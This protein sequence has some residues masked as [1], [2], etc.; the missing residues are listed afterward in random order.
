MIDLGTDVEG[1]PP[2]ALGDAG[3]SAS[4][5]N[6]RYQRLLDYAPSSSAAAARQAVAIAQL[7]GSFTAAA[8]AAARTIVEELALP[9]EERTAVPIV[10][11]ESALDA[12]APSA[13]PSGKAASRA[14][15]LR[16][17]REA[18]AAKAA[19][20][21]SG[22]ALISGF[23]H[24]GMFF[25]F[26]CERD[27]SRAASAALDL[28]VASSDDDDAA[29]AAAARV[30][31]K[32]AGVE[33]RASGEVQRAALRAYRESTEYA[34]ASERSA[35]TASGVTA[36]PPAR[37]C[38]ALSCVA[39]VYGVRLHAVAVAPLLAKASLRYG[40]SPMA[41]GFVD[42]DA[43]AR[44]LV[45]ALGRQLGL[46]PHTIV[47]VSGGTLPLSSRVQVH[48]GTDGRYYVL[49]VG[50]LTPPE[51]GGAPLPPGFDDEKRAKDAAAEAQAFVATCRLRPEW[52]GGGEGECSFLP[53][54]FTRIL[55]TV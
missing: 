31:R 39:D 38:S 35:T 40:A 24:G 14:A 45:A 21:G 8:V 6:G 15:R 34:L 37:L 11:D 46:K 43:T 33:V 32:R 10:F 12:K 26:A 55:L 52:R 23:L 51:F 54:H 16:Q 49:E 41:A 2:L 47:A 25:R 19:G 28:D 3:L 22:P 44:E 9:E 36:A 20:G 18:K 4:D 27:A 29:A 30:Q 13:S 53:L 1:L 5:W 7:E 17:M 42:D 50:E 48:S